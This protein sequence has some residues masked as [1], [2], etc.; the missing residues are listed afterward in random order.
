ML[1][2]CLQ[3]YC[4]GISLTFSIGFKTCQTKLHA[5]SPLLH[6]ASWYVLAFEEQSNVTDMCACPWCSAR[7]AFLQLAPEGNHVEVLNSIAQCAEGLVASA[8]AKLL[9]Y[10]TF[11]C[12]CQA[13]P[14]KAWVL[15]TVKIGTYLRMAQIRLAFNNLHC[16]N[17]QLNLDLSPECAAKCGS[18]SSG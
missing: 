12:I 18:R 1:T 14:A 13:A 8:T 2:V 10:M 3:L 4:H 7:D 5:V 17:L 9:R 16:Q 6:A 11:A 15:S